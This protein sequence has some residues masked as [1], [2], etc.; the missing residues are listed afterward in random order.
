MERK[1]R[2]SCPEGARGA[3]TAKT[4]VGDGANMDREAIAKIVVQSFFTVYNQLGYGFLEKVYE[5][6]LLL[7]LTERG[8]EVLQQEPIE[9]FYR[10]Q[11]MGDY[12]ADLLVAKSVIV[13]V[14]AVEHIALEHEAQVINYLKATNINIGFVVNFGKQPEIKRKIY[15]TARR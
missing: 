8:L 9:V 3:K 2:S 15:E 1:L 13:E 5:N 11:V 4:A 12:Y 7:E 6:A 10:G 14:K